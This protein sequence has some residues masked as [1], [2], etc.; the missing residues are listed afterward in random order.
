MGISQDSQGWASA[1]ALMVGGYPVLDARSETGFFI[2]LYPLS[3]QRQGLLIASLALEKALLEAHQLSSEIQREYESVGQLK[4]W[5]KNFFK[6]LFVRRETL[7]KRELA[8]GKETLAI[9][10]LL[11]RATER[12]PTLPNQR[13]FHLQPFEDRRTAVAE[14]LA[15]CA[16]LGVDEEAQSSFQ[17]LLNYMDKSKS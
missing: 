8:E 2:R 13:Y 16:T 9:N 12:I 15:W 6:R 17:A 7:T 10:D 11:A 1:H 3:E 5:I 14:G 4:R